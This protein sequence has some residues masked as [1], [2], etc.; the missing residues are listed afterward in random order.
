MKPQISRVLC[1]TALQLVIATSGLAQLIRSEEYLP[2][3]DP[4]YG[5]YYRGNQGRIEQPLRW[6]YHEGWR[7]GRKDRD[8]GR[9]ADPKNSA[10]Y[11]RVPVHQSDSTLSREQYERVYRSAFVRGYE[12]GYRL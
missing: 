8:L 6:G 1:V 4:G 7:Q 9:G 2:P 5:L 12:H 11:Q 3:P 10:T